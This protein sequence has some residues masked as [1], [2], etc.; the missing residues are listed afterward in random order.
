MKQR[1]KM[2]TK[3]FPT[4]VVAGNRILDMMFGTRGWWEPRVSISW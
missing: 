1:I 4:P 2:T 3:R